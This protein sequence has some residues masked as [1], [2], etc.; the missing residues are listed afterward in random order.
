MH[1]RSPG[2]LKQNAA[3]TFLRKLWLEK[4]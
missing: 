3:L 1:F 2:N 4:I